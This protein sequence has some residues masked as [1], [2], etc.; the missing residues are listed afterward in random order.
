MMIKW[1][2]V[3]Q[4]KKIPKSKTINLFK[5]FLRDLEINPNKSIPIQVI[6]R[7]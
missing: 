6:S 4:E 7:K 3:N 1:I 2:I 5:L